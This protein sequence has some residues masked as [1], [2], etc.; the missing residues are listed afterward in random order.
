MTQSDRPLFP[1]AEDGKKNSGARK[2][3]KCDTIRR[4]EN[5]KTWLQ[6]SVVMFDMA[7]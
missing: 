6:F 1:V 3:T 5:P 4:R 7:I 2:D